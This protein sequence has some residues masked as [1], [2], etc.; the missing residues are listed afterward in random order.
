MLQ[1]NVEE[2]F[3]IK[4]SLKEINADIKDAKKSHE[5]TEEIEEMSKKLKETKTKLANDPILNDLK[6][7][8]DALKE[9]FVLLKDIIKQELIDEG[10]EQVEYE[11]KVIKLIQVMKEESSKEEKKKS[12]KKE[13]DKTDIQIDENVKVQ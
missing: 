6:E 10:K 12:G 9:R 7:D 1:T 5:L 8:A 4:K 13:W 3:K 2:Y 11:G